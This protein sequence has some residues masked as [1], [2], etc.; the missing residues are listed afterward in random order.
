MSVTLQDTLELTA[1]K[2]PERDAIVYPRR[3]QRW[4]YA[5]FD[6]KEWY[7]TGDLGYRD[8][9]DSLWVVDRKDDMIITGGENVYPTEVEDVLFSHPDVVEAAVLGESHDEWG[10]VVVAYIVGEVDED[11][12]DQYLRESSDLA[13]FKRPRAYYFVEQLPKNPSG[14]VQKF[15]LRER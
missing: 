11:A 12:L 6:E 8:E 15:K 14:K 9:D 10:E 13:D 5:E 3:D 7:Y 2:Y 1:D 4:T